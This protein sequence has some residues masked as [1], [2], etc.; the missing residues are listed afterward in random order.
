MTLALAD[1]QTSLL[2]DTCR[3][4]QTTTEC[5]VFHHFFSGLF[6]SVSHLQHPHVHLSF[7]LPLFSSCSPILLSVPLLHP[8]PAPI[9][10]HLW[11]CLRFS[12]PVRQP[13]PSPPQY[14]TP[15][16]PPAPPG[17]SKVAPRPRG[18]AKGLLLGILPES[19]PLQ[20][21]V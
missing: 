20:G 7:S 6:C 5:F 3:G 10:P 13:R 17:S 21:N 18:P 4:C 11:A 19:R 15:P 8:P 2:S 12:T 16:T 1:I 9:L 14:P